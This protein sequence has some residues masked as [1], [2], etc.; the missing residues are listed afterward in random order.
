MVLVVPRKHDHGKRTL[1]GELVE[2]TKGIDLILANIG[3]GGVDKASG[4]L[5]NRSYY[6]WQ[7]WFMT[8]FA[9]VP[10]GAARHDIGIVGTS[11]QSGRRR[12]RV[13]RSSGRASVG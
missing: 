2:A 5:A 3:D 4:A 1:V 6:L 7:I 9:E 10:A 8:A 13:G 12:R 11:R